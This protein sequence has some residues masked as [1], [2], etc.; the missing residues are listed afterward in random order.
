MWWL[1]NADG[2]LVCTAESKAAAE[3]MLDDWLVDYRYI[4]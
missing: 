2:E 4:G 3:K 1:I